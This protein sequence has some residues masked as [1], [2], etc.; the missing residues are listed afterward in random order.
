[1]T[2]SSSV[3]A[4]PTF[5]VTVT[6]GGLVVNSTGDAG[7]ATPG[8]GACD[9]GGTNSQGATE[10]TLRAAIDEANALAG[11]DTIDFNIPTT[12]PGYAASPL[13]Y[14]ISPATELTTVIDPVD[15][16]GT[17]QPGYP[18]TPIIVL[19]GNSV[20]AASAGLR[21]EAGNS[22]VR[23]LVIGRFTDDGL[24]L[25]TNGGNT[26]QG[27]YIGVDVTGSID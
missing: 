23:G 19:D 13:S 14:T 18:G 5:D 1:M 20:A 2:S 26:V 4:T 15:I 12:E 11:V 24:V 17:T 16:D 6:V 9:T 22:L 21:I 25:L 10:C 3:V 27:N 8:D 7:D